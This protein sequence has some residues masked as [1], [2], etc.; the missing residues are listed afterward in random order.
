MIL[1][2]SSFASVIPVKTG[3]KAWV[4]FRKAGGCR[5]EVWPGDFSPEKYSWTQSENGFI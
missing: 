3:E 5:A 1:R 2:V 4:C